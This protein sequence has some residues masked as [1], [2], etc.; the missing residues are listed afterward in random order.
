MNAV[1]LDP[2]PFE[3]LTEEFL[4]NYHRYADFLYRCYMDSQPHHKLSPLN[5]HFS[6]YASGSS[7]IRACG[8]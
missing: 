8:T 5:F 3:M 6:L 1:F 2:P 4:R 7:R